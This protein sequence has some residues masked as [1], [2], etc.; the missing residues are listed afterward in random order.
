MAEGMERV[1][2]EVSGRLI[3][4]MAPNGVTPVLT[5]ARVEELG[6]SAAIF[7][8]LTAMAAMTTVEKVLRRLKETGDS[9]HPELESFDF[10]RACR[11]PGHDASSPS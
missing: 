8:A 5:V 11:P 1:Y 4:S 6:F 9:E 2:R 3:A 10:K 7:P